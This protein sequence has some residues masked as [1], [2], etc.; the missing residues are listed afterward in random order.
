MRRRDLLAGLGG[1]AGTGLA[2]CLASAPGDTPS[3]PTSPSPDPTDSGDHPVTPAEQSFAVLDRHCGQGENAA[4]VRFEDD[5]VVVEGVIGGRDT[6]DTARVASA[7]IH[8]DVFTLVV[9]VVEEPHTATVGC[10][11][12]LTDI[13]YRYRASSPRGGPATV[14]VVHLTAA[15][16]RTVT[17]AERP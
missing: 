15:G 8:L 12:C 5:R 4:T 9:E 1:L 10:G 14:R 7:G 17:V 11:Q 3:P 13:A 16:R 6:C 2:G